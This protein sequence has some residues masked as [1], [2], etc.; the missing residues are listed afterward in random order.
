MN[1]SITIGYLGPEGT[2]S[3]LAARSIY[4]KGRFLPSKTVTGVFENLIEGK[5]DVGVVPWENSLNGS[6]GK[7]MDLMVEHCGQIIKDN[8]K[9]KFE[10]PKL[11]IVGEIEYKIEHCL[12]KYA[13]VMK[14]D[15]IVS[16]PQAIEQCS[17]FIEKMG[18]E[19]LAVASTAEAARLAEKH[20]TWAAI[21]HGGLAK[22]YGLSV[23][24]TKISDEE[25]NY[26]RFAIIGNNPAKNP[27]KTS[28]AFVV[29]NDPGALYDALLPF[30]EHEIN[31]SKIE[32]RPLRNGNKRWE[33][34][35]LVD[36]ESAADGPEVKKAFEEMKELCPYLRVLGSYEK[37]IA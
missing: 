20:P 22:P 4:D 15:R 30:R 26:T 17:K 6:V 25:E 36:F 16:H 9:T 14:I 33:Y 5:V 32:S 1:K 2:Y 19:T 37:T 24:R 11:Y 27:N 13:D 28:I 3:E 35:M 7:T 21:G 23:V 34:I 29:K 10:N 31:M 12:L 8:G 18:V